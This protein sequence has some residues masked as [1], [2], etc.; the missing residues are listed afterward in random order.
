[1]SIYLKTVIYKLSC[2]DPSITQVYVGSSTDIQK[3]LQRHK[4]CCNNPNGPKYN[5]KLY[6]FIRENQG[7][8]RWR[9]TILELLPCT[10]KVD[11]SRRER[12]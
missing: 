4:S 5:Y 12:Y 11:A 7:W 2:L 6:R 3:R 8:A 10:T 9:L 1:M